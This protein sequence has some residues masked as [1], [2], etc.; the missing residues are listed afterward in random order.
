MIT[1]GKKWHYLSV[2][3][4]SALLRGITSNHDGDFYWLNCPHSYRTKDRL[5]K[6]LNVCKDHDYCSVEIPNKDN[7][8]SKDNHGEKYM[9]TPFIIYAD[10]EFLL[11]KMSTCHNNPKESSTN[12]INKH[13]PSGYS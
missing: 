3:K 13:M 1:D 4:L 11:E 8:I 5:Q 10:K 7:K 9:K 2:K 6:H 12:K